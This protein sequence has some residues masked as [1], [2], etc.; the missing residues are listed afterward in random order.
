MMLT[1]TWYTQPFYG[2]CT[3]QLV[4]DS[5]LSSELEDFVG[6]KFYCL[7]ALSMQLAHSD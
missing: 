6:A 1:S 4:L 5:S 7:Y 3:G 2:H